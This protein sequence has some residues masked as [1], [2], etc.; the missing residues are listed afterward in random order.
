MNKNFEEFQQLGQLNVD[1]TIRLFGE[2]SKGWQTIAADMT[3]FTKRSFED[4]A[5]TL[6]KLLSA[7]SAEQALE[8]QSSFTRRTYDGYVY[9][10]SKIG[11]IYAELARETYKPFERILRTAHRQEST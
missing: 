10:L 3:D 8:I 2:W 1:T 6:Q 9:Q 11:G 7:K 4:G 5:A